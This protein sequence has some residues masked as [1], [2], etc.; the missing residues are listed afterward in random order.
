M[1]VQCPWDNSMTQCF[2]V[3]PSQGLARVSQAEVNGSPQQA[4]SSSHLCLLSPYM[5]LFQK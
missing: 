3:S 2:P 4:G 5:A 1:A